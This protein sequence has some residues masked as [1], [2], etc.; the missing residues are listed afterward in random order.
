[1]VPGAIAG[2][3]VPLGDHDFQDALIQVQPVPE[4]GSML[5]LG[6]GLIGLAGAI[7]RRMKK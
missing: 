1:L 5:L 2:H 3:G 4:P 6:T 7:R